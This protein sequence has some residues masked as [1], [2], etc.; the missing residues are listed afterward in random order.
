VAC[1]GSCK[2]AQFYH[3]CNG[4]CLSRSQPCNGAC[5]AGAPT[6]G[7]RCLME[8]V[9]RGRYHACGPHACLSTDV[10]CNG[11]CPPGTTQCGPAQCLPE[12]KRR[13]YYEC[14]GA[15][16]TALTACEGACPAAGTHTCGSPSGCCSKELE[17]ILFGLENPIAAK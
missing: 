7:P 1:E 10:P 4:S 5:P 8:P 9:L 17:K 14:K 6:C 15:C 16:V 2:L 11:T 3:A 13:A 12:G